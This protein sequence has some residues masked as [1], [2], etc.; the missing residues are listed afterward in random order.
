MAQIIVEATEKLRPDAAALYALELA[1][2]SLSGGG[3]GV[4]L[5]I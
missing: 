3:A 4:M 2:R 5:F 1:R